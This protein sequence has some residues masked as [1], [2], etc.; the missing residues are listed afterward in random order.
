MVYLRPEGLFRKYRHP[1]Q[2]L[3]GIVS[4]FIVILTS[5]PLYGNGNGRSENNMPEGTFREEVRPAWSVCLFQLC[6][7]FF[8]PCLSVIGAHL[9]VP[10]LQRYADAAQS[11]CAVIFLFSLRHHNMQI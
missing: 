10:R 6:F 7:G 5:F 3:H 8:Q 2:P 11:F 4:V 1:L 9:Y